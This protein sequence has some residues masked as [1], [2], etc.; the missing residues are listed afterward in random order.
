MQT[1]TVKFLAW[2]H[3]L[4]ADLH[5]PLASDRAYLQE[6]SELYQFV[7]DSRLLWRVWMIDEWGRFWI[8]VERMGHA[9]RPEFHTLM[10]DEGTFDKIECEAYEVEAESGLADSGAGVEPNG[11]ARPSSLS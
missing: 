6:T 11:G 2:V 9:Q 4:P 8:S 3:S 1:A 7:I 5:K 10:I